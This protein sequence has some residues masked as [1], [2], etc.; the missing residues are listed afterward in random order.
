MKVIN[1]DLIMKRAYEIWEQSG[2]PHGLD[3]EHW[4]Q[5]ERELL[6]AASNIETAQPAQVAT[7]KSPEKT[8]AEKVAAKTGPRRPASGASARPR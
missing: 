5:A 7:E 3:K 8:V 2:R 6:D 4:L 1:Q